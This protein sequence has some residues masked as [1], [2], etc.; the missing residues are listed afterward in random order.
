MQKPGVKKVVQFEDKRAAR[1][2]ARE[3]LRAMGAAEWEGITA[4]I[5]RRLTGAWWWWMGSPLGLYAGREGEPGTEGLAR[6]AE[7][8]GW[9]VAYPA[10]TADGGYEWREGGG[11]WRTG[12]WGI[13]EPGEGA[14][15]LEAGELRLVV[16]PGLAFDRSGTRLGHGGG[17]FDRLLAG[18]DGAF[19]VGVCAD[20]QLTG[21][22]PRGAHDVGMDAVTTEKRVVFAAGAEE[23]LARLFGGGR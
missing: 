15:R 22:L 4:A 19:V 14:R 6:W 16:V 3:G 9:T 12:R 5:E 11:E 1:A 2:W 20:W 23:K 10:G 13:R 8:H 18:A 7:G 17:F 21:R